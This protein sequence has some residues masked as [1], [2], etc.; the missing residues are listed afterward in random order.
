MTAVSKEPIELEGF[1]KYAEKTIAEWTVPGMA[2]GVVKDGEVVYAKGFGYRE[3]W[4][5]SSL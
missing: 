4:K 2:V 5:I 1:P 3:M